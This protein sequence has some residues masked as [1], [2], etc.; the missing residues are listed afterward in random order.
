[1]NAKGITKTKLTKTYPQIAKILDEI[2]SKDKSKNYWFFVN[3]SGKYMDKEGKPRTV[4]MGAVIDILSE[5]G[6]D[7]AITATKN[8]KKKLLWGK[9]ENI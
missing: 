5:Y 8:P 6:F 9:L 3:Y 4:S 1:M 7:V 2:Y